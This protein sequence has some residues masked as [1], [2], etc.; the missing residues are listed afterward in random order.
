MK[1]EPKTISCFG[2]PE[3]RPSP[4]NI[5]KGDP[6]LGTCE[7]DEIIFIDNHFTMFLSDS[8]GVQEP[9]SAVWRHRA[10][11]LPD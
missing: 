5:P 7:P 2:F 9:G 6:G 3:R 1:T 11:G 8:T 10:S 4:L